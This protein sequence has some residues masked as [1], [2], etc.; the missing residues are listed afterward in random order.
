MSLIG[1]AAAIGGPL[2]MPA[3]RDRGGASGQGQ[4]GAEARRDVPAVAQ[5]PTPADPS[6]NDN[7]RGRGLRS[8]RNHIGQAIRIDRFGR[9]DNVDG[10]NKPADLA[11]FRSQV[12]EE[13]L[14]DVLSRNPG[15]VVDVIFRENLR[16]GIDVD[17]YLF[18]LKSRIER[19]VEKS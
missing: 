3:R 13:L 17:L 8:F 18:E 1:S 5:I 16:R 4:R 12:S 11:A 7:L 15:F 19:T 10:F 6:V 9:N 2:I 14:P